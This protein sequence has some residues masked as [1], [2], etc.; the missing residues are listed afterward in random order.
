MPLWSLTPGHCFAERIGVSESFFGN[1]NGNLPDGSTSPNS[2]AAAA[3]PSCSPGY[4]ISSTPRTLA[5]HGIDTGL[6]VCSTTIV[7]G[8]TDAI[9]ATSWSCDTGER[10]AQPNN[11]QVRWAAV[12][13][14]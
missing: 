5:S 13:V 1:V 10:G 6:P 14:V 3:L 7:C 12:C 2:S 11:V 4:H 9:C 8:L